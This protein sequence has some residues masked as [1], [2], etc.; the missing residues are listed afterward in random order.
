VPASLSSLIVP[1]TKDDVRRNLVGLLRVVGFPVASWAPSS[2][3]RALVEIFSE[4]LADLSTTVSKIA[5]G[6][7][8]SL[9]E[10]EWLTLVAAEFFGVERKPAVFAQGLAVL[11]DAGS[12]GPF[13]ILPNQLWA[14]S[15]SGL[16]FT[17]VTGGVLPLGG[18]LVL[19]WKAESSGASFNAP[20]GDLASLL[21]PLPGVT[22]SNP[23]LTGSGSWLVTQGVDIESDAALR[24]RC[25]EKWSSLGAGGNAPAYAY[26]A[27]NASPQITRVRVLEAFPLGGQVTVICAGPSGA[28]TDPKTLADVSAYL[29]DGRRPQCVKVHVRSA[30][31]RVIVVAGEVRVRA[32]MKDVA[33]AFVSAQLTIMQRTFDIGEKVPIAELVQRIMDAP[34]AINVVLVNEATGVALVPGKDDIVLAFDEVAS[35]VDKLKWI[36][37]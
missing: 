31:S 34:G 2:V 35:F 10:N 14:A 11:T 26:H 8:L 16:R 21:T 6:G 23:A 1:L 13:T 28:I 7:F 12:A 5:R 20:V 27:K 29:E 37:E 17:N 32:T 19:E 9:A 4:S 24:L 18:K 36:A 33:V 15:K 3:P 22:V 30:V 25:Q